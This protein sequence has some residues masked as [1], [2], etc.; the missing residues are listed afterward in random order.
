M[1]KDSAYTSD[2]QDDEI[3]T[4]GPTLA[5]DIRHVQD[6]VKSCQMTRS[7]LP[8]LRSSAQHLSQLSRSKSEF[9]DQ[10][11]I[12]LETVGVAAAGKG[13][14]SVELLEAINR[15]RQ[16]ASLKSTHPLTVSQDDNEAEK[17][18]DIQRVM[19]IINSR[20]IPNEP[21]VKFAA[22]RLKTR[23][24][25]QPDLTGQTASDLG[26]MRNC[27]SGIEMFSDAEKESFRRLLK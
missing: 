22:N 16:D 24:W 6:V 21:A 11:L 13:A 5:E 8:S 25:F 2:A 23:N 15:L 1:P 26:L 18:T 27:L 9:T 12:A 20:R 3:A 7:N 14:L 17:L 19:N 4:D 10:T